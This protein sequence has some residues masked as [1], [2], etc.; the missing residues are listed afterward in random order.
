[1]RSLDLILQGKDTTIEE[2]MPASARETDNQSDIGSGR[3]YSTEVANTVY[4]LLIKKEKQKA[5][6]S[7]V[8]IQSEIYNLQDQETGILSRSFEKEN[9]L[10]KQAKLTIGESQ[11]FTFAPK[12]S[13]SCSGG[14]GKRSRV[15]RKPI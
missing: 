3:K 6:D 8:S 9:E 15:D 4:R 7:L 1:M 2:E 5:Y 14:S 12:E 10:L 13:I 11:N